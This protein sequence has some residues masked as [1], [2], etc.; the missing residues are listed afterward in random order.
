MKDDVLLI[1]YPWWGNGHRDN[2]FWEAIWEKSGEVHNH[3]PKQHLVEEAI[4]RGYKYKVLRHH[5]NGEI[6]V[7]ET[8]V[9]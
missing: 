1:R 2:R 5:R 9:T 3:N 7:V 4:E 6:S 8:N